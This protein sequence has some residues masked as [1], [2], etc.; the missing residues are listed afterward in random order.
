MS[1]AVALQNAENRHFSSCCP[2]SLAF[3]PAPEV[4]LI[5][6]SV[7]QARRILRVARDG[8]PDRVDGPVNSPIGKT[9]L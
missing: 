8:H 9:K 7:Q 5:D 4:G 3:A 6:L 1:P 2:A